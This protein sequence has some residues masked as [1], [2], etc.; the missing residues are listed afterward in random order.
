MPLAH[1]GLRGCGLALPS[2]LPSEG[3]DIHGLL[4]DLLQR[5]PTVVAVLSSVGQAVPVDGCR[6]AQGV[7]LV[8]PLGEIKKVDRFEPRVFACWLEP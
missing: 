1:H 4:V 5:A 8:S 2:A 7:G 6:W 3:P